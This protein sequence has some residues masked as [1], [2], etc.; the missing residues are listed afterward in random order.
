M[1]A[2]AAPN[3]L[4]MGSDVLVMGSR[5]NEPSITEKGHDC[6]GVYRAAG[7]RNGATEYVRDGGGILYFEKGYWKLLGATTAKPGIMMGGWH[8]SQ[9]GS[10]N[11]PPFGRW[12]KN[13]CIKTEET[14][15]YAGLKLVKKGATIVKAVVDKVEK[16]ATEKVVADKAAAAK[17]LQDAEDAQLNAAIAA[18]LEIS[19]AV[20]APAAPAMPPAVGRV[21]RWGEGLEA[22]AAGSRNFL[23]QGFEVTLDVSEAIARFGHSASHVAQI[24]EAGRV[25]ASTSPTP[26]AS[27][28]AA[29]LYA[30]TEETLLY[31]T[32]NYTMRTPHTP[33]T[34]TDTEL[35]RYC[36]YI[37]HTERALSSL[38]TH[39]SEVLGKVYRGIKILL[40]P[41]IYA[42][43]KRIT[44]QAFS[45][46]TKKQTATLEF[47]SVLPGRKLS[48]S[49][50][51]IDSITAKD[52]RHFSTFPSEEEVLF[53]PN[54]QFK[55]EKLV[56]SEQEKR[57]E[58]DQLCAYDMTDLDVYVLKQ[59]A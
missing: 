35:K 36:D 21:K 48:G 34:P 10:A 37:V 40:N 22:P 50:F 4:T 43:G 28:H 12:V 14:R 39:V 59:I 15:N 42:L 20:A 32:L 18:S 6:D 33:N 54:S 25:K 41:D 31:G 19:E 29:A 13:A 26:L 47:V 57:A 11:E 2:A 1:A 52:I 49:L 51:V 3:P 27:A 24:M 55:V 45:S 38:P 30:Y 17:A 23:P 56:T 16:G 9:S 44:W 8:F 53:P 46:S 7:T 5:D 58:L